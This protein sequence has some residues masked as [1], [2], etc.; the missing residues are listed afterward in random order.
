MKSYVP[1]LS[2]RYLWFHKVSSG[3]GMLGVTLGVGLVIVVVGVMDGFQTRIKQSFISNT[4]PVIVEPF[5]D[6][7][8]DLL[9]KSLKERIPGVV[10]ASPVVSTWTLLCAKGH[11]VEDA[12]PCSVV[13][14]DA[15]REL[16][17]SDLA[18]KLRR[19]HSSR[20]AETPY[21]L[22]P[23]A[24]PREPFLLPEDEREMARRSRSEKQGVLLGRRVFERIGS[25][26]G[27]QVQ[28][29]T[30]RR[31]PGGANGGREIEITGVQELFTVTGIFDGQ[32]YEF[33]DIV[34]MDRR[35]A[36]SFFRGGLKREADKV[37]LLLADPEQ[38][39]EVKRAIEA[40]SEGLVA[41]S[42]RK[43][44][45]SAMRP[46]E[47]STWKWVHRKILAAVDTERVLLIVITGFSFIVVAFLIGSTQ[48]MLVVEKT[49]EIG[50]LRS[51]GASVAG[52]SAV[53]VGNAFFIGTIGALAG[54]GLGAAVTTN[55]QE[56]VDVLKR[57]GMELF[58]EDIYRFSD[59]PIDVKLPTVL[60]ICGGAVLF[61]LLGSLLPA[62][63]AS[64]LDPVES[65]HHE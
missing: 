7:D 52:T 44:G 32:D 62:V 23:P 34:L 51:L 26:I 30:L 40:Q 11:D 21:M 33:N 57:N 47:V 25:R 50:V 35:D 4:T 9:V 18:S 6:L 65:L 48:S 63:R 15:A 36:L 53:F 37:R 16:V 38:C 28:I 17:V 29:F 13:G 43:G 64:T 22:L 39:D 19:G 24:T 31:K 54:W 8:A 2:L 60:A 3:L 46:L 14:I 12:V 41:A 58:P 49:R 56:I 55:I 61:S 10:E 27:S 5:Y 45:R 1:F 42:L 20:A 59:V